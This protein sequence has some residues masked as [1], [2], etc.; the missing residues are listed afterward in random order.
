[1]K[2]DWAFMQL[3]GLIQLGFF[4]HQDREFQSIVDNLLIKEVA[5]T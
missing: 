4:L 1:M 5:I 3:M 2:R